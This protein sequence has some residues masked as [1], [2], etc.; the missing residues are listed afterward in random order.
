MKFIDKHV[1]RDERF[2][3]GVDETTG[4]F[5]LS[6]PVSNP[7]VDYEEYYEIDQAQYDACPTNMEELRE[8]AA[9]CRKR[10]NDSRLII[11]PG[12]LRGNPL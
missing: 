1:F 9:K 3:V 10:E 6:I 2:S 12:R 4:K 7:L 11:K 8:I 5:Y